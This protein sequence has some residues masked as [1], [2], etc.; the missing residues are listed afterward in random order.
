VSVTSS[1]TTGISLIRRNNDS[2][3]KDE[4]W[5]GNIPRGRVLPTDLGV[6]VVKL[7]YNF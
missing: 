1:F 5:D 3:F 7:Y 4:R 2:A 6:V